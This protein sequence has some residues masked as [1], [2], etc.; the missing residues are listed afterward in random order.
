MIL[1]VLAVCT[2]VV[3]TLRMCRSVRARNRRLYFFNY[4]SLVS[5]SS[6]RCLADNTVGPITDA[7][8]QYHQHK[9][10]L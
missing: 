5:G 10:V 7:R 1:N 9:R 6:G 2:I 4:S 8:S 3:R